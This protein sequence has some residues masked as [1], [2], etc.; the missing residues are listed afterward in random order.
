MCNHNPNCWKWI[1]QITIQVWLKSWPQWEG[2]TKLYKIILLIE[3]V[4]SHYYSTQCMVDYII[5]PWFFTPSY[6]RIL[7]HTLFS[8]SYPLWLSDTLRLDFGLHGLALINR[9]LAEVAQGEAQDKLVLGAYS[10]APPGTP[11]EGHAALASGRWETQGTEVH[12]QVL[13][14]I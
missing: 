5:W 6:F 7:F 1:F 8:A 3:L 4:T 14:P 12:H 2:T 9:I 10:L 11:G 13:M